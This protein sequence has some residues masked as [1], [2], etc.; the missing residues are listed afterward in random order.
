MRAQGVEVVP[1]HVRNFQRGI[2]R[3]DGADLAG[4]P[5]EAIGDFELE[6]AARHQLH[7]DADAEE[8]AAIVAD[9]AGQGFCQAGHCEQSALAV[10]VGAD[11]RQDDAIGGR[12]VFGA[13]CHEDL[14]RRFALSRGAL[15]SLCSRMQIAGAVVD[16]GDALHVNSGSRRKEAPQHAQLMR[17]ITGKCSGLVLGRLPRVEKADFTFLEVCAA[18]DTYLGPAERA[19]RPAFEVHGF[20]AEDDAEH[21]QCQQIGCRAVRRAA[22]SPTTIEVASAR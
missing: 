18:D 10:G 3:G 17:G 13:R 22:S 20:E 9:G 1:A 19:Q 16:D 11:A 15:E 4:N 7:A 21:Q 14:R 8:W 5:A 2:G 12:D 6:A